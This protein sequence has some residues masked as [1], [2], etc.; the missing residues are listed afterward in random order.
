[1]S[2]IGCG[3]EANP[4]TYGTD[5][6]SGHG[7]VFA[8]LYADE[9]ITIWFFPRGQIPTN[10]QSGQTTD[11]STWNAKYKMVEFSSG[12]TCDTKKYFNNQTIVRLP[13][14]LATIFYHNLNLILRLCI[15]YQYYLLWRC[16]LGLAVSVG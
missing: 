9:G 12:S 4:G 1:M 7:G 13:P 5:F 14:I 15:D 11:P 2:S 16:Y 3:I 8:I 10:L 6:N